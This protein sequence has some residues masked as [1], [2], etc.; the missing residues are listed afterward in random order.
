MCLRHLFPGLRTKWAHFTLRWIC[1]FFDPYTLFTLLT[2]LFRNTS[3]H[4]SPRRKSF[5]FSQEHH[6]FFGQPASS[7]TTVVGCISSWLEASNNYLDGALT[8]WRWQESKPHC[9]EKV[10]TACR[11]T[12]HSA[13]GLAVRVLTPI[14]LQLDLG[15]LR[16][17]GLVHD[18]DDARPGRSARRSAQGRKANLEIKQD[19]SRLE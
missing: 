13:R 11:I 6:T 12:I 19:P 1:L 4:T 16:S 7:T 17:V 3:G 14:A 9:S 15:W 5:S 18:K 2:F 10:K 8:G